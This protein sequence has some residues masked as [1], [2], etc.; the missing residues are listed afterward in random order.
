M[1]D[2][3]PDGF[4]REDFGED[5]DTEELVERFGKSQKEAVAILASPL[6]SPEGEFLQEGRGGG[7]NPMPAER[8]GALMHL[9]QVL[10]T[11]QDTFRQ[12]RNL[13]R[14]DDLSERQLETRKTL[15]ENALFLLDELEIAIKN[16]GR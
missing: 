12:I 11:T 7:L 9:Q 14:A 6:Q 10:E 4:R 13:A 3:F 2:A 8:S 1:P 16:A 5:P 15:Q